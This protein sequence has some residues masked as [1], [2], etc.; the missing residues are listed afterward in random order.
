M[1]C[2]ECDDADELKM[3]IAISLCVTV[4]NSTV[5]YAKYLDILL[6][7]RNGKSENSESR[8]CGM[9]GSSNQLFIYLFYQLIDSAIQLTIG[10]T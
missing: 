9:F 3:V 8:I 7:H 1:T 5:S 10:F 6:K 4:D 2:V